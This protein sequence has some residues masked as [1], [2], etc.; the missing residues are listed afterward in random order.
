MRRGEKVKSAIR[1][2]LRSV[3]VAGGLLLCLCAPLALAEEAN[4]RTEYFTRF[5]ASD[6]YASGYVG[7]GYALSKVDT[8]RRVFASALSEPTAATTTKARF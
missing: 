1:G 6:N 2:C 5:E 7:A 8:T 4:P 3:G